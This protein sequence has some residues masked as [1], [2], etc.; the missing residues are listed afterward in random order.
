MVIDSAKPSLHLLN[1]ATLNWI[2]IGIWSVHMCNC[3][4]SLSHESSFTTIYSSCVAD[5][6]D[7]V[8]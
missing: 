1:W 6:L 4:A 2:I 3:E 8:M 7:H 5:G